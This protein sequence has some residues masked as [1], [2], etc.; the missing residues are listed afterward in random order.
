MTSIHDVARVTGVSTATVSRALR[1]LPN[2]SPQTREL[3][4]AAASRLGYVPSPSA[5]G[6][7]GGR[8]RAVAIVIPSTG[9]WFYNRV[10]EGADSVLRR[11]GFDTFLVILAADQHDRERLFSNALLRKR[12]GRRHR[13]RHRLHR[14]RAAG[15]ARS[16]HAGDGR[17]RAGPRRPQRRRRRRRRAPPLRRSTCWPSGTG[18]SGTSA[19]RPSAGWTTASARTARRRGGR[20]SRGTASSPRARRGYGV[21]QFLMPPARV[22]ATAMLRSREPAHRD[23]RRLRRDGLRRAHRRR[24]TSGCGCRRTLSVIGIDDHD[25]SELVRAH[26]DAP[27]PVR[28]GPDRR[29]DRAGRAGGAAG[30]GR[31]RA[32]ARAARAPPQHRSGPR[33]LLTRG[34]RLGLRPQGSRQAGA[35]ERLL[36]LLE[37]GADARQEQQAVRDDQQQDGEQRGRR[38][39]DRHQRQDGQDHG[40]EPP[41]CGGRRGTAPPPTRPRPRRSPRSR[42]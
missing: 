37:P 36:A 16:R 8:H 28:A 23:L 9:R 27:G 13:A 42:R 21:G 31:R 22:A 17:R 24:P 26:H 39:Q 5:S 29:A 6:L 12:L 7:S 11:E 40:P 35:R 15:A 18:G 14:G 1:G 41:P 2:V 3:V 25:W 20:R 33:A 10:V 19:A 34:A 38:E 30:R 4:Q 32:A